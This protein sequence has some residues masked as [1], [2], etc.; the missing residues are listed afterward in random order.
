MRTP[1]SIP[2]LG[3]MG[4]HFQKLGWQKLFTSKDMR[5]LSFQQDPEPS[6]I[7]RA[8]PYYYAVLLYG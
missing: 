4:E 1:S 8:H 7:K 3:G 2:P 5:D 6:T